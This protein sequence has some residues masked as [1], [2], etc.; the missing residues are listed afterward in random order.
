[1]SRPVKFR[2]APAAFRLIKR[3]SRWSVRVRVAKG[4]YKQRASGSVHRAAAKEFAVHWI[5][6]E[7][8]GLCRL[9]GIHPTPVPS[10]P[11]DAPVAT[12][13]PLI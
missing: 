1:M 4:V 7:F 5:K 11:A 8:P 12:T 2:P 3:G 10:A 9:L 13:A 6:E